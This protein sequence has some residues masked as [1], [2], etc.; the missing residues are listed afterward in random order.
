MAFIVKIKNLVE[1]LPPWILK[2][3]QFLPYDFRLGPKYR[4]IKR[5]ISRTQSK[6]SN[7]TDDCYAELHSLL[8][9]AY[10]N[11][12]FYRSF[13]S[14]KGFSPN[15][16]RSMSDWEKVPIVT[17]SDLRDISL[18]DRTARNAKSYITLNTGGTSGSPLSFRVGA[19]AF[20]V[21]WAHMHSIWELFGY[22]FRQAKVTFRGKHF[23]RSLKY[24][25]NPI[26]NEY[27]VNSA[28][29]IA[30]LVKDVGQLFTS[31]LA[32]WIHGYP[33]LVAE[34][35]NAIDSLATNQ[36]SAIA[37][38][39]KGVLL[40]SEAPLKI[41]RDSISEHLSGNIVSWYGH[42]E[43]ALLARETEEDVYESFPSYGYSEAVL[44]KLQSKYKL[45]ST[46]LH[47][48]VH[49]FIR[50]DTGDLVDVIDSD[51][52][53]GKLEFRVTGG[54]VGEF[55]IDKD[56][57]KHSL[58]AIIFGR[59]HR[60]FSEASHLQICQPK[61]GELIFVI[62]V[63]CQRSG[64]T[65]SSFDL[66]GL[67]FDF[68]ILLVRSPIRTLNGKIKLKLSFNDLTDVHR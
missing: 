3:F 63:G 1:G 68:S 37:N 45:V 40:G 32:S 58:T 29:P 10:E 33:S 47:N 21:E 44:C 61:E 17:K 38:K 53:I 13:Y 4:K 19:D 18:E 30:E 26:H 43:M 51:K 39:V 11:V 52:K 23:D 9:F 66:K 55:V 34:F 8:T 15:D 48:R 67:N 35:A 7:E 42:S 12:P 41:Y 20:A 54:R 27:I 59:H 49:P 14:S 65:L 60:A 31:G 36:K 24:K 62:T 28:V 64:L 16:F 5:H 57:V 56:G 2:P 25:F 22:S 46:S 50:Y 6:M